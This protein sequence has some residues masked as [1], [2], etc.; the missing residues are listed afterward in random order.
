MRYIRCMDI[1][2]RLINRMSDD[3]NNDFRSGRST[4]TKNRKE[5]ELFELLCSDSIRQENEIHHTLYD[6]PNEMAYHSLRKRLLRSLSDFLA[7]RKFSMEQAGYTVSLRLLYDADLMIER[8]DAIAANHFF[9]KAENNAI[10]SHK[11]IVLHSLYSLQQNHILFLKVEPEELQRKIERN[12]ENL[13]AASKLNS[14]FASILKEMEAN[15]KGG[16]SPDIKSIITRIFYTEELMRHAMNDAEFMYKLVVLIRS[17]AVSSK[18]YD[19]FEPYVIKVYNHLKMQHAFYDGPSGLEIRFLYMIAQAC[20]RQWKFEDTMKWLNE[21]EACLP[22]ENAD[23]HPIYSN[24]ILM[25]AAV[26]AYTDH[27]ED[28][29]KLME[30]TLKASAAKLTPSVVLN[31]LLNLS[32]YYFSV[33]E[34]KKANQT[35][36]KI[37]QNDRWLD[38]NM[39]KEWRLKKEMIEVIFQYDLDRVDI[40]ETRIHNIR[41]SFSSLLGLP[42]YQRADLF[43]TYI[44]RLINEPSVASQPAFIAEVTSGGLRSPSQTED[45]QAITFFCWLRSKMEKRPYYEVLMEWVDNNCNKARQNDGQMISGEDER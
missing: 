45:I 8:N 9:T 23:Q 40:S 11:Y 36:L 33:G 4:K 39:G 38:E 19:D 15:K 2:E 44:L 10:K 14:A 43:L 6:P 16:N 3:E 13:V 18:T 41:K 37:H 30:N 25:R 12:L 7:S 31:L 35:I 34:Y 32:V 26:A 1:L 27:R 42:S 24:W 28:A 22:K 20:Y 5:F 21:I 17:I 29:I